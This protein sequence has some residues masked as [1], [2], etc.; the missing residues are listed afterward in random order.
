M[1]GSHGACRPDWGGLCKNNV[2]RRGPESGAPTFQDVDALLVG[3]VGVGVVGR[4]E[5]AAVDV[6]HPGAAVVLVGGL[7][8]MVALSFCGAERRG[9]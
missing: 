2:S 8:A 9:G 3:G 1:A 5:H 6:A 4:H 7:G